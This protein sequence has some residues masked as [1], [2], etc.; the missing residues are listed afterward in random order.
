VDSDGDGLA[1]S[2]ETGTGVYRGPGDTGTY[3]DNPDSDGDGAPDGEE[4]RAGTVPTDPGSVFTVVG[5]DPDDGSNFMLRWTAGTDV[6][7]RV[8]CAYDLQE[9]FTN[10]LSPP[11]AGSSDGTNVFVLTDWANRQMYLRVG[12]EE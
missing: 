3:P 2:A 10:V 1:D 11:L 8:Y 9:P 7:F 5:L 12:I 6:T 4:M